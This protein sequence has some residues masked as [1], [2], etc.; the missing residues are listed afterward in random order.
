[1]HLYEQGVELFDRLIASLEEG[2]SD[3]ANTD[4][5][6]AKQEVSLAHSVV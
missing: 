2:S 1:M 3:H 5:A 4:D 6:A